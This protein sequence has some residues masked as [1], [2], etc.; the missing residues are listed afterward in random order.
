MNTP[1]SFRSVTYS[2]INFINIHC[3]SPPGSGDSA[4]GKKKLAFASIRIYNIMRKTDIN[5]QQLSK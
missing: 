4:G 3:T 2:L 1:A 5:K